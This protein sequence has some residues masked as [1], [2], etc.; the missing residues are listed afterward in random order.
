MI[1]RALQ[2]FSVLLFGFGLMLASGCNQSYK[3]V[4]S[5][6]ADQIVPTTKSLLWKIEGNGLKKAS[7]LFGTIHVIPKDQL[8]LRPEVDA[9]LKASKFIVFE[10]DI[11]DMTN[12]K[13]QFAL[14]SKA[15]MK[16]GV[17]LRDLLK[18]EDYAY[19]RTYMDKS[20]LP[21]TM[22]E[23][24]KPLFISSLVGQSKDESGASEQTSSVEL[25]LYK[26]AKKL[27]IRSAGLET[28]DYQISLFD[29]IPYKQQAEMLVESLRATASE[30]EPGAAELSTLVQIYNDED[31][32]A[33]QAMMEE[34]GMGIKG[35]EDVLLYDR[36]QNWIKP[37]SD[38]M[39]NQPAFFA[40]GAGHLGG[41]KGVIALLRKAGYKVEAIGQKAAQP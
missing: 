41:E 23:R 20:G 8:K 13:A 22:I 38:I 14:L 25:V 2:Q 40:V 34:D 35:F 19:V 36:N 39:A 33:M 16:D 3:K 7:F 6:Q 32:Q 12:I 27:N 37:M 31:I 24:M 30:S 26:K 10:I 15:F 4:Y 11:K 1:N 28:T 5:Y 9:A 17:T 21:S 29:K 18:A